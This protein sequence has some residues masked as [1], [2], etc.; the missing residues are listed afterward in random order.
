MTS[1]EF[2]TGFIH[3]LTINNIKH[4]VVGYPDINYISEARD[5]TLFI[6]EYSIREIF[7]KEGLQNA[8]KKVSESINESI[9][10]I[11]NY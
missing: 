8:H 7:M 3:L 5:N 9:T 11:K 4:Y 10:K 1:T 2:L 6:N